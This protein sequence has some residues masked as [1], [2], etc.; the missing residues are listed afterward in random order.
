[1]IEFLS[2][3]VGS[4]PY[5]LAIVVGTAVFFVLIGIAMSKQ[6]G[7]SAIGIAAG[8]FSVLFIGIAL[9]GSI[10]YN[11][12]ED[13]VWSIDQKPHER[14]L[15]SVDGELRTWSHPT[16][17]MRNSSG[18]TI[19]VNGIVGD[20]DKVSGNSFEVVYDHDRLETVE[21]FSKTCEEY[22]AGRLVQTH[23]WKH[24]VIHLK[25]GE[26]SGESKA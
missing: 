4:S 1:M 6:T 24:Y 22:H 10:L 14:T 8:A 21:E 26:S 15:V 7:N 2:V 13:N 19:T 25:K 20:Y 11:A 12:S 17:V 3:F 23:N 5:A 9:Y 18:A 16:I